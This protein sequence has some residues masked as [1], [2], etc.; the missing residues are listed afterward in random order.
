MA[1]PAASALLEKDS[2]TQGLILAPAPSTDR[3]GTVA[4]P[5]PTGG[6]APTSLGAPANAGD[7]YGGDQGAGEAGRDASVPASTSPVIFVSLAALVVGF[8]LL[9]AARNGRRNAP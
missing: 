6:S 1:T 5:A 3:T 4:L 7:Q 2:A 8:G 9:I